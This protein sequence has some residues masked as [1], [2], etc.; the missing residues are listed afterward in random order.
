MEE[1]RKCPFCGGEADISQSLVSGYGL[2][3]RNYNYEVFCVECG[4]RTR[5]FY[6][7]EFEAIVAWNRRVT[8]NIG[9]K[10]CCEQGEEQ[11]V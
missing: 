2:S 1:L 3:G 9:K 11:E 5:F 10:E 6:D 7:S 8:Q 4:C